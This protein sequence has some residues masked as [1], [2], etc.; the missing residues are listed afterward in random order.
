MEKT[1]ERYSIKFDYDEY[2]ECSSPMLALVPNF[3]G[4]FESFFFDNIAKEFANVD[5]FIRDK[6]EP[7]CDA[8]TLGFIVISTGYMEALWCNCY[9]DYSLSSQCPINNPSLSEKL[10]EPREVNWSKDMLACALQLKDIYDKQDDGI[11]DRTWRVDL[12]KPVSDYNLVKS[13][14]CTRDCTTEIFLWELLFS[15]IHEVKHV[16]LKSKTNTLREE[17]ECDMYALRKLMELKTKKEDKRYNFFNKRMLT[18]VSLAGL[19]LSSAIHAEEKD[20]IHPH[21]LSR[22]DAFISGVSKI[23]NNSKDLPYEALHDEYD[24]RPAIQYAAHIMFWRIQYFVLDLAGDDLRQEG[25]N[26]IRK[27]YN[28]PLELYITARAYI[29]KFCECRYS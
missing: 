15:L 19:F 9:F 6:K 3:I 16:M 4:V 12:P 20:E 8:S 21:A 11:E 10:W 27:V 7:L 18:I 24:I 5:I 14:F 1:L 23:F 26:L 28:E 2:S 22:L 25:I 17:K 13:N 29:Y